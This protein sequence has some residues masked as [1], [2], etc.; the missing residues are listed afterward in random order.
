MRT[1]DKTSK[2]KWQLISFVGTTNY[3]DT[4]YSFEEGNTINEKFCGIALTKYLL[5]NSPKDSGAILFLCTKESY[6]MHASSLKEKLENMGIS[7]KQYEF[8][9]FSENNQRDLF[10]ELFEK[11][12]KLEVE[13]LYLDIT[14][15]F[16]DIPFLLYPELL[17]FRETF[18]IEIQV[19]YA[20]GT[21]KEGFSFEKANAS[22]EIIDW[23]FATKIF[24]NKGEGKEFAKLLDKIYQQL[25]A[26][27]SSPDD[28]K[29]INLINK[30]SKY[31]NEFS[32]HFNSVDIYTVGKSAWTLTEII[33]KFEKEDVFALFDYPWVIKTMLNQI[34]S[35]L[36]KVKCSWKQKSEI[37]L[38]A[39]EIIREQNILKWYLE[40]EDYKSAIVLF[41]ELII[42]YY[43]YGKQIK[44]FL[45]HEL[46]D[47]ITKEIT[48]NL[49][50]CTKDG[51]EKINEL[52]MIWEELSPV[53]NYISHTGSKQD[54][55]PRNYPE[56]HLPTLKKLA[57]Y[58]TDEILSFFP[59]FVTPLV[60][61]TV[62]AIKLQTKS[63][64]LPPH[65]KKMK[66]D[67]N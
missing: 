8:L 14:N 64:K 42:N 20:R 6:E 27:S 49:K 17:F 19:L 31:M 32:V 45:K 7:N 33:E 36:E 21:L 16:R 46:R 56:N 44:S 67:F 25:K 26:L 54:H 24:I 23:L 18:K 57:A 10:A 47:D 58:T 43:F 37:E 3:Q 48:S 65:E 22:T 11:L 63:A 5:K 34:S 53:R 4:T 55:F 2:N 12:R 41:R 9:F 13:T 59:D 30:M 50:E 62:I 66:Y 15:T 39:Q 38:N 61:K 60:S 29:K 1:E 28:F 51:S 35:Y 52:E 40:I